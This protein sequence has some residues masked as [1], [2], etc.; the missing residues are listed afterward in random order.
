MLEHLSPA[1]LTE[2]IAQATDPELLAALDDIP[3]IVQSSI[4]FAATQGTQWVLAIQGRGGWPAVDAVWARPPE[5]T[6]QILHPEK[7]E[8]NE[9]PMEVA[10]PDDLPARLGDGWSVVL[11]DTLGEHQLGI[12]LSGEDAPN[13]IVTTLAAAAAQAASG[14]GGDRVALLA[15]PNDATAIV[16]MT[17]WDTAADAGEFAERAE[18]VL[19]ELGLRGTVVRQP[20]SPSAS[21]LIGSDDAVVLSLDRELGVTGV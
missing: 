19:A 3:P 7:Y 10:M 4:L 16:L 5:S 2:L 12:W 21:V 11:E 13:G 15:G 20:G 17:E 18:A 9:R 14:W 8:T 1:E 6:E